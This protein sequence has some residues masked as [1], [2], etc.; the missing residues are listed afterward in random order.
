MKNHRCFNVISAIVILI[1][2]IMLAR[3]SYIIVFA[4]DN[5]NYEE[6]STDS[7][8]QD[9]REYV[10]PISEY[11]YQ[12][13]KMAKKM[14]KIYEKAMK[15]DIK[16][17]VYVEEVSKG[18][19][20]SE[21]KISYKK[22]IDKEKAAYKY[23]GELNKNNEPDGEGILLDKWDD[24][25]YDYYSEYFAAV[26]YIG[27]FNNGFKEGYGIEYD[28]DWGGGMFKLQYE[29]EYKKGKY[30]GKGIVYLGSNA[31]I[32]IEVEF[33][34]ILSNQVYGYSSYDSDTE[35]NYDTLFERYDG[36][37]L[38][39]MPLFSTLK[40]YEGKLKNGEFNGEGKEYFGS[41]GSLS[42]E[43]KFKDGTYHGK[44]TLYF[45]NGNVKYKGKFRYGEY[46]GKGK[47]YDEQGNVVH[48]GK[49]K[50]GKIA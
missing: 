36:N 43:G 8:K 7:I 4:N 46:H 41:Q 10:F 2:F 17:F 21:K 1:G 34:A 9:I 32:E 30:D 42:Y 11:P 29:G 40:Y 23:Y 3:S 28:I 24:D 31:D 13:E 49:F 6:N 18:G 35:Y 25:E 14:M 20:F 37:K 26:Y 33:R 19:I 48:K 45:D 27:K 16:D 38:T 50:Y 39:I 44:G 12:N 22:T 5:G 47:L 15:A